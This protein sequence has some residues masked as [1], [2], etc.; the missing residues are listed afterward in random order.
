LAPP[1]ESERASGAPDILALFDDVQDQVE[2]TFPGARPTADGG[3]LLDE[4][5]SARVSYVK[6]VADADVSDRR[7]AIVVRLAGSVGVV[8]GA[9]VGAHA[10]GLW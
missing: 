4:L 5:A 3:E 1:N 7:A 10:V 2:R 8:G 6:R 9:A